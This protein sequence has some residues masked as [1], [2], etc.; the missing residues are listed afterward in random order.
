MEEIQE[1]DF[2]LNITRYV[3]TTEPEVPVDIREVQA[4]LDVLEKER[5]E[6]LKRLNK[7]L[8][9]LGF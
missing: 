6:T 1:N 9:N 7:Y 4:M 2:N 3:D 5:T 8:K